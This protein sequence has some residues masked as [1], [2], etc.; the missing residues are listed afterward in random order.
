MFQITDREQ[1]QPRCRSSRC[2]DQVLQKRRGDPRPQERPCRWL[3]FLQQSLPNGRHSFA[4]ESKASANRSQH[5]SSTRFQAPKDIRPGETI[6]L[7]VVQAAI[8]YLHGEDMTEKYIARNDI[9]LFLAARAFGITSLEEQI[10]KHLTDKLDH[11]VGL[12]ATQIQIIELVDALRDLYGRLGGEGDVEIGRE[13]A[14]I[15]TGA[16]AHACC[17]KFPV[18]RKSPEFMGLLKEVPVLAYDILASDVEVITG[19]EYGRVSVEGED[20][21]MGEEGSK[22]VVPEVVENVAEAIVEEVTVEVAEEV[23]RTVEE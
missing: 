18:L 11:Q 16:A 7:E 22:D 6:S 2:D 21:K 1:R 5:P 17:R 15:V 8:N 19:V 9:P 10:E 13:V 3:H 23:V 14:G 4:R 12:I 20:V